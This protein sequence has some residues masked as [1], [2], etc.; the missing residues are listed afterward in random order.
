[1]PHRSDPSHPAPL[2][3]R[4]RLQQLAI[5]VQVV[6]S[7]SVLAA[8]GA[9]AMTQ[10]AVSKS[11]Q[12]LEDQVGARLFERSKAGMRL[13]EAGAVFESHARLMLS[14]LRYLS[15]D[16]NALETG[17]SGQLVVGTLIAAS[18]TLLPQALGLLRQ[19]APGVGVTVK[20]G[21]NSTLF[22]QLL[23]GEVD[24]VLGMLPDEAALAPQPGGSLLRHVPLFGEGLDV[25]LSAR[26]PLA[27]QDSIGAEQLGGLEWI[28]PTRESA[29]YPAVQKFF[30][31]R[32]LKLPDQPIES[33]S[34]LTNLE[35]IVQWNM[36]AMMPRSAARR[37]EQL[38]LVKTL[39]FA[40]LEQVTRVG[41]TVRADRE[42]SALVQN[43]IRVLQ[44]A[45][46]PAG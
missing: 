45:S 23:K 33:V 30:R 35:L 38:G 42:R 25:V 16:L 22:P 26:H 5:F 10:P 27:A 46:G 40:E 8:C 9:L 32:R 11:I 34:I 39:A 4:L 18:A 3:R 12:D 29:N 17:A 7:G 36:A 41:Y 31:K 44:D 14:Q 37:F 28:L 19:R 21:S 15:E 13:T 1:M 43:F 20:V 6:E 2:A 24:I